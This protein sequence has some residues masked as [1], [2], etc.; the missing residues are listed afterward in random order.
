MGVGFDVLCVAGAVVWALGLGLTV[1]ATGTIDART[2]GA[3]E[4]DGDGF[5]RCL[6]FDGVGDG[7]VTAC[8]TGR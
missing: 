8:A 5:L 4:A 6:C 1:D 3:T 7:F 2:L